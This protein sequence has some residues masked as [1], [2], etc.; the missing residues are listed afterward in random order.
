MQYGAHTTHNVAGMEMSFPYFSNAMI[1]TAYACIPDFDS[2]LLVFAFYPLAIY[3]IYCLAYITKCHLFYCV[4]HVKI[5]Y[6]LSQFMMQP[7]T[8]VYL[9]SWEF[10]SVHICSVDVET[11]AFFLYPASSFIQV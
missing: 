1:W 4:L 2:F 11:C 9:P 6:N 7:L 10:E 3:T 8:D 5:A